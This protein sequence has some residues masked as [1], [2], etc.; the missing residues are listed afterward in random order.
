M[1]TEF[2]ALSKEFRDSVLVDYNN[3]IYHISS[4]TQES[5]TNAGFLDLDRFWF[6]LINKDIKQFIYLVGGTDNVILWTPHKVM[7]KYPV[8]IEDQSIFNTIDKNSLQCI[9]PVYI[10]NVN[11]W[12]VMQNILKKCGMCMRFISEKEE[13]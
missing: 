10:E 4:F 6:C 1:K 5:F 3:F 9:K 11:Q 13:E 12:K 8:L 7:V 2:L